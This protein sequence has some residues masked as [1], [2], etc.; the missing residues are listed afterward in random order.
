MTANPPSDSDVALAGMIIDA[1]LREY[2]SLRD[3]ILRIRA[4]QTQLVVFSIGGLAAVV[5]S[6]FFSQVASTPRLFVPVL[7]VAAPLLGLVVVAYLG[8]AAMILVIGGYL[9]ARAHELQDVA[10]S[11]TADRTSVPAGFLTWDQTAME[12]STKFATPE[13]MF[14]WG[15]AS[16]EVFVV[17]VLAVLTL[18]IASVLCIA[19]PDGQLPFAVPWAVLDWLVALGV[20][21]WSLASYRHFAKGSG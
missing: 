12:Q 3:E 10:R 6:A 7:L 17:A 5:S 4:R 9:V 11:V 2:M 8:E 19:H 20:T 1:Q 21:A 18:V 13:G 15:P 16:L 14:A